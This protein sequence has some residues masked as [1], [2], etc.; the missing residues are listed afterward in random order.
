MLAIFIEP[1]SD[2]KKFI[3]KWKLKSKKYSNSNFISHPPHAT[4]F[5]ANIKN[6]KQVEKEIFQVTNNLKSFEIVVNK[7]DVFL[8]DSLTNKDTIFLNIKKNKNYLIYKK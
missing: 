3:I 8:N 6:Q 5:I 4:I 2:L 1:K 7:T